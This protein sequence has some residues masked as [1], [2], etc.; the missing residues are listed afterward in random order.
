MKIDTKIENKQALISIIGRIDTKTSEILKNKIDS[1][2]EQDL[3]SIKLDFKN[4]DYIS[5]SGLRV[6]LCTQK[7]MA[8]IDN[9]SK[10]EI[11]NP[12]QEVAESLSITGFGDIVNIT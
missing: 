11:M 2:F 4:V 10:L 1:L 8:E 6:I 12:N 7:R 3:M 5:S 9:E